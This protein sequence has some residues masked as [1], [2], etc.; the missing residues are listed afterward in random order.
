[1]PSF[2]DA[3]GKVSLGAKYKVVVFEFNANKHDLGH[4]AGQRPP[5]NELERIGDHIPSPAR[6]FCLQPYRQND[7]GW[8]QG[9]LFLTP[10]QVWG[11]PP[12]YVTRMVSN[13]YLPK[14]VGPRC[15]VP[16]M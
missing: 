11:Q 3:L 12:Y 8:D 6:P 5:I 1:M 9:L 7:N 10:S 13:H 15:R 4:C 16:A 2:I 14:C